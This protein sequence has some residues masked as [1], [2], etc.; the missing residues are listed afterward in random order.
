MQIEYGI[1]IANI[2]PGT[3]AEKTGLL[4]GDLLISVNSQKLRDPIDFMYYSADDNLYI[5]LKRKGKI[6][7]VYMKRDENKELGIIFKP[8]KVMTCKN[9]CIFCFVK[10]LPKG[11]RKSLYIKDEDYRM[12]FIYGNYITMTNLSKKDKRR[13][14]EQKLS[15][16]YISV[17]STNRILRNKLIGNI[18]AP[19]IIK[20]LKFLAD[21]KIRF[22]VQIV[23]CPDYND[24]RE[25]QRT[26]TD[27]YKFYPYILSIAVVPVG[28]TIHRKENIK[29]VEKKDAEKTLE[30]ILTFQKKLIK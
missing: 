30:I 25:L 9:N 23:L 6:V 21:N 3:I 26:L 24:G 22:N 20:E 11:L 12:S 4:P 13:M 7:N 19:D 8:F 17:H 5:D 18:K 29:P 14:I 2:I 27:L 16:L 1:E 10:Q 28:L 15:P